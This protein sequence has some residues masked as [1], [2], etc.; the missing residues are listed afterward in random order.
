MKGSSAKSVSTWKAGTPATPFGTSLTY[1]NQLSGKNV[2]QELAERLVAHTDCTV[3][4][5]RHDCKMKWHVEPTN[6][7]GDYTILLRAPFD[8]NEQGAIYHS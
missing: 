8:L 7:P 2:E 5:V 3:E 1:G 6:G 4:S